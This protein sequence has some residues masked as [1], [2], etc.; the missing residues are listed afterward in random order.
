MSYQRE[1][2]DDMLSYQRESTMSS[3]WKG[4][5]YRNMRSDTR[6]IAIVIFHYNFDK[7]RFFLSVQTTV[8]LGD[9]FFPVHIISSSKPLLFGHIYTSLCAVIYNTSANHLRLR[10]NIIKNIPDSVELRIQ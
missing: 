8:N 4:V 10:S 2:D 7:Q 9:N 5:K 1:F 3:Y 6:K